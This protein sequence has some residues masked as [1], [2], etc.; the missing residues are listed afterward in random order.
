MS[1]PNKD[2]QSQ[3]LSIL[4]IF[5]RLLKNYFTT[6]DFDRSIRIRRKLDD[7]DTEL[8]GLRSLFTVERQAVTL[9][10]LCNICNLEPMDG[11]LAIPFERPEVEYMLNIL[12]GVDIDRKSTRLN[13]SH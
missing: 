12:Y 10:R 3:L 11:M 9:M 6:A 8:V 13:S 7:A 2:C 4:V 1:D 5:L